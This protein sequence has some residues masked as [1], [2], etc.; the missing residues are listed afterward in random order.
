MKFEREVLLVRQ[1]SLLS[2]RRPFFGIFS[3]AADCGRRR[4]RE[5]ERRQG[6]EECAAEGIVALQVASPVR[7]VWV[8]PAQN[9]RIPE[10]TEYVYKF[11][12]RCNIFSR[13]NLYKLHEALVPIASIISKTLER[14]S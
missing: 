6:S 12:L 8:A 11:V 7:Y 14:K 10:N 13:P 3:S 1:V 9:M 5:F 4:E 2:R